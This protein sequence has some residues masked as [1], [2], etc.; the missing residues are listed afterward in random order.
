MI[1]VFF[2]ELEL[3]GM[4]IGAASFT[5][6]HLAILFFCLLYCIGTVGVL[7]QILPVFRSGQVAAIFMMHFM[8]AIALDIFVYII[9]FHIA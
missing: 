2:N 9:H 8:I 3:L 6:V 4:A 1:V 7:A 5:A